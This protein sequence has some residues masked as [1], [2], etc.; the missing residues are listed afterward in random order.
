MHWNITNHA[1]EWCANLVVGK[2]FLL[3]AG[4]RDR[5]LVCTLGVAHGL[6]GLIVC[7]A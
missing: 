5:A 7:L 1:G 2:R 3:C 4:L 6:N